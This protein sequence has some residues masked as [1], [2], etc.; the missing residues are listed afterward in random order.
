MPEM[1]QL[2]WHDGV[3]VRESDAETARAALAARLAD[4]D[5]QEAAAKDDAAPVMLDQQSVGRLSRMDALQRQ[6]MAQETARRRA[7]ER[8]RITAALA[9]IDEGEYGWCARC[10]E[11]IAPERLAL[12]PAVALCRACAR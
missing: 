6:A 5:M 7:L 4:L 10:G 2:R 11:E 1:R 12:D 9:R 3:F 8:R